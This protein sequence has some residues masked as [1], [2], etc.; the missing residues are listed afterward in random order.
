MNF[1]Q[2]NEIF[3]LFFILFS[4]YNI[5]TRINEDIFDY[6]V[7]SKYYTGD[8]KNKNSLFN[9]KYDFFKNNDLYL[10]SFNKGIKSS[11]D[12]E[13]LELYERAEFYSILANIHFDEV[14]KKMNKTSLECWT[15][16]KLAHTLGK[17]SLTGEQ[18]K[19]DS[20]T[21]S[22]MNSKIS[23]SKN[24]NFKSDPFDNIM[25]ST[26]SFNSSYTNP[27]NSSSSYS[28]SSDSN[29][30]KHSMF[31]GGADDDAWDNTYD[32]QKILSLALTRIFEPIN[33]S[34]RFKN[35]FHIKKDFLK[36]S[37]ID[38]TGIDFLEFNNPIYINS[39][40]SATLWRGFISLREARKNL[41]ASIIKNIKLNPNDKFNV[42]K[43]KI[44][45]VIST[46]NNEINKE[47][48][49]T[50]SIFSSGLSTQINSTS[51]ISN[52]FS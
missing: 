43:T 9:I 47:N 5:L 46:I 24:Y 2:I 40:V 32:S 39:D 27:L 13:S 11:K 7:S 50:F 51:G 20:N 44:N 49:S 30:F 8:K 45:E 10:Q 29:S 17:S 31:K 22:K 19:Q 16:T 38:N 42:L 23:E 34:S 41:I 37:F 18:V 52:L 33:L 48:K 28:Y 21:I 6:I 36:K 4:Y 3:H 26:S 25:T 12:F 15:V 1:Y 14:Y 35:K